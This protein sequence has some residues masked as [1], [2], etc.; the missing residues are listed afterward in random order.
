MHGDQAMSVMRS[1]LKDDCVPVMRR[2][3]AVV[4]IKNRI[5]TANL[6]DYL[7]DGNM[8]F[9]NQY[10]NVV[11]LSQTAR[12]FIISDKRIRRQS[13]FEYRDKKSKTTLSCIILIILSYQMQN[14]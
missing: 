11:D 14:F 8:N 4:L 9:R 7:V 10:Q 5:C 2:L 13:F 3:V 12:W 6:L 1:A